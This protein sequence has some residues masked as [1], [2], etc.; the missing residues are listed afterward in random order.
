MGSQLLVGRATDNRQINMVELKILDIGNF[1]D[2]SK[3][4]L[5]DL[6]LAFPLQR[7]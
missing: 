7:G 5:K 3:P 2:Y 4:S 6:L 1:D